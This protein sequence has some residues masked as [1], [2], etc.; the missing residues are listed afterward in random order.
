MGTRVILIGVIYS[1]AIAI[2]YLIP[3][4]TSNP[5]I[6]RGLPLAMCYSASNMYAGIQQ[7]PLQLFRKMKRLTRS[8]IIARIS[9]I[10]VLLPVV[11]LFFANVD[12]QQSSEAD[13]VL[14]VAFCL[15]IFSVVVSSIGQNV[16][17]HL[18]T[19]DLLPLKIRFD[20]S[21]IKKLLSSN[22]RF[23]FSYFFSSFHTL[24][25]LMFL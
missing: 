7:L 3:A 23:G 11:Y 10:A 25:V 20:F 16:E 13:V 21:F 17:M 5:F 9:Q 4:Y 8:L 15:V 12:F 14:I 22:R 18:R 2:A 6:I 19:K 1:L 24:L